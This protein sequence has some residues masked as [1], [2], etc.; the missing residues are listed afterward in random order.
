MT[1]KLYAY[2]REAIEDYLAPSKLASCQMTQGEVERIEDC[3]SLYQEGY[4]E[5]K[6]LYDTLQK[7][8]LHVLKTQLPAFDS[9]VPASIQHYLLEKGRKTNLPSDTWMKLI[10]T[11]LHTQVSIT[12]ALLQAIPEV[13]TLQYNQPLTAEDYEAYIQGSFPLIAQLS[14]MELASLALLMCHLTTDL[15]SMQLAP[16]ALYCETDSH[17]RKSIHIHPTILHMHRESLPDYA[18]SSQPHYGCPARTAIA[19]HQS[20]L[21]AVHTWHVHQAQDHL[22]PLTDY[23]SAELLLERATAPDPFHPYSRDYIAQLATQPSALHEKLHTE[24]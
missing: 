22:F 12:W 20:I 3:I 13:Y 19:E 14:S 15:K 7:M 2:L 4:I 17:G 6:E 10:Q 8:S 18:P 16:E 1:S 24:Q 21:R 9:T 5:R 11:G 23:I